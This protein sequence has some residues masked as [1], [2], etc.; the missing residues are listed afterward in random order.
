VVG[1]ES[2]ITERQGKRLFAIQKS[3]GLSDDDVKDEMKRMGLNCHRDNIPRSRYNEVIDAIDPD[4][5]FH[6]KE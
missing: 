4:F 3:L 6:K 1:G 2:S 5:K